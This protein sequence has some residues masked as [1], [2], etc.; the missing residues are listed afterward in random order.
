MC[1]VKIHKLQQRFRLQDYNVRKS[2]RSKFISVR[3]RV[4][5][6]IV[7]YVDFKEY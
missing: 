6:K 3:T 2:Q 4:G 5:K 7:L 1:G